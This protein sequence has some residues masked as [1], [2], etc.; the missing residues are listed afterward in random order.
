LATSDVL[1]IVTSAS[2]E[3]TSARHAGIRAGIQQRASM[4][5]LSFPTSGIA[6][7]VVAAGMIARPTRQKL[8]GIELIACSTGLAETGYAITGQLLD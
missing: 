7:E 8:S 5:P 2:V 6:A 4:P 3:R 1:I